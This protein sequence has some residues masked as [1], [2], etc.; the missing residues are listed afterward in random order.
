[1]SEQLWCVHIEGPDDFI[2]MASQEAAQR[3]ASAINAYVERSG[4]AQSAARAR[5]VAMDW[6]FAPEGHARALESDWED[7]QRMPHRKQQGGPSQN[8]LTN[9]ARRVKE[10]IEV[11]RGA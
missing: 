4:Q 10:L 2:A 9:I 1:M 3:E 8:I 5:A 11:A 7:L 6:P